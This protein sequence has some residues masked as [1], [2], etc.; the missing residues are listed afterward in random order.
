MRNVVRELITS[1]QS[2][3]DGQ[4]QHWERQ[5]P[6]RWEVGELHFRA[7]ERLLVIKFEYKR[8]KETVEDVL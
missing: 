7:G 6:T 4:V 5:D 1:L 8:A 3:M 2:D